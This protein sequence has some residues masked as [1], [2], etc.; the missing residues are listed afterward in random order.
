MPDNPVADHRLDSWKEIATYLRRDITTVQRWEKR[1][2]MPVHRHLHDRLG[3]V[4]AFTS[5]LDA[6]TESRRSRGQAIDAPIATTEPIARKP[7][8]IYIAS[9]IAVIMIIV[10][11]VWWMRRTPASAENPLAG[12]RFTRL[13]D[14]EGVEQAAA[15]S[16]DGR[17]VAFLS[18]REGPVDVWLTQPGTEQFHNLTRGKVREL[19]NPDIRLLG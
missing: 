8:M 12:A 11:V 18:N 9:L 15:I 1:E 7:R 10:A 2:G 19:V 14:F 4:Y 13:T 17:F 3:S 6:W 16:R 5:E